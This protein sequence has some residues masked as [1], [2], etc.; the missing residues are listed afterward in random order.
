MTAYRVSIGGTHFNIRILS[1]PCQPE[2]KVQVDDEVLT[3]VV[4]PLD[5]ADAPVLLAQ[6]A[7]STDGTHAAPAAVSDLTDVATNGQQMLSPLPGTVTQVSVEPGQQ[8]V[9]GDE[10]LVIEAMKMNNQIRSPRHGTV[11]KILIRVGQQVRHG[12][13]LLTWTD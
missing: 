9:R 3:V 2:V 5:G 1:D 6:R 7:G 4:S 11:G 10:L 8:V 12:E 13:P